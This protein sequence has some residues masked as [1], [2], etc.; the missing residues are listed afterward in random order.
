MMKSRNSTFK[1][2]T[3]LGKQARYASQALTLLNAQQKNAA[4]LAMANALRSHCETIKSAN[5]KD[6]RIAK[7]AKLSSALMDRLLLNDARIESMAQGIIK[8]SKLPDPIGKILD[9]QR[10]PNGL[11][12]RKTRVP[13]GVIAAIYESRPNVT[14][15][16]AALCLKTSNAVILRGGSEALYSNNAIATALLEGLRKS[17]IPQHALQFINTTNRDAVRHLVQMRDYIDLVIPRGGEN[18][19]KLLTRISRVPM[20]KHYKGVCHVYVDDTADLE[21]A[22]QICENAK[23]QRP[24]VC[25]A[26]ETLL[27]NKKIATKFLP[28]L[29]ENFNKYPVELRGDILA[30]KIIPSMQP[31]KPADWETEYLDLILAVKIVD[32]VAAA[33]AHI[34]QFGSHHSDAIVT[35]SDIAKQKFLQEV[36]SAVV[37]VN[38]STRFTD[39]GEF[40]MG[41]EIGI[42]TD[43]FHARGPMGLEELTTYKYVVLGNGQ[44]RS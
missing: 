4:L 3:Q 17:D 44:I 38:A 11:T 33:I 43:K 20:I 42:S 5:A 37:Y 2:I 8:V 35:N 14:T 32:D 12:I 1:T 23:C 18:L 29:A 13:L 28:S 40:G 34:N 10:R 39:G 41:A 9:E 19:I 31:A 22:L 25:N 24:G 16:I 7:K 21:M 36:D 30:R 6:L 26:M 15:D 27:V